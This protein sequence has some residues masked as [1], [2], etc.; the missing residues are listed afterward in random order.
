[1]KF[2]DSEPCTMYVLKCFLNIC[3]KGEIGYAGRP[4]PVGDIGEQ[5]DIG[6][7]GLFGFRGEEGNAIRN[8][9]DQ[10]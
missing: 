6:G 5:G 7:R 3:F 10:K 4:G 8:I 1:M 9:I 2:V